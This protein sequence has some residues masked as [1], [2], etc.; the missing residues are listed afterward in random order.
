MSGKCPKCGN[1]H[2]K[3]GFIYLGEDKWE[4]CK[5]HYIGTTKDF[6]II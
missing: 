5:C 6:D 1:E 3:K 2:I 4:C